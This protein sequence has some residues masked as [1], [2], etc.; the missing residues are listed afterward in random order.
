MPD[1]K[2][3]NMLVIITDQQTHDS[4]AALGNPR[5][6]TPAMD[7]LVRRGV[8][9]THCQATYPLCSPSRSSVFTSRM[10]S[11]TGVY[12]N[13]LEI[14]E[15]MPTLGRWFR[16]QAGYQTAYAGK[17][18]I[19]PTY[20]SQIDGYDVISSGIAHQG[21]VSDPALTLAVE[22]YMR[23]RA[24]D[25]QPWLI[26]A[27]Y[28]QPH[29]ICQWLRNRRPTPDSDRF[30]MTDDQLPPLPEKF[31]PPTNE[32]SHMAELRETLEPA[33]GQWSDRGFRA[34]R[35]DYDRHVEMIDAEIARLLLTLD[36][37][38]QT[39]DTV[40]VFLS[41][42]GEGVG[43]HRM[44]RKGDLYDASVHVP[45]VMTCPAR[46][47]GDRQVSQVVSTLD[48]FPTL[49]DLANI[50][51]PPQARGLS[52]QPMLEQPDASL[53]R[54]FVAAEAMGNTTRMIRSQRYKYIEHINGEYMLFDL[55]TDPGETCN[56][57]QDPAYHDALIQHQTFM[58]QWLDGL[59]IDP[60]LPEDLRWG[61]LCF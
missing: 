48:V 18:H 20:P 43:E 13:N 61:A 3:P 40:I 10:P 26:V 53:P 25:A 16:E 27:S 21:T 36:D 17:W 29:D 28:M 33:T 55:Q 31:A 4:I 14:R 54:D 39:D 47:A 50:P 49:C 2:P 23:A 60:R 34:Y 30:P 44:T 22:G 58:A 37:L 52:L 42:H 5:V 8:A 32:A 57:A 12:E 11:E 41:D 19:P 9:F 56:V 1:I 24:E 7:A 35:H 45:L 38:G 51:A 15:G 59:D 6:Q 46:F